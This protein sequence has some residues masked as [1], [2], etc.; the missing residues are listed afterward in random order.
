MSWIYL[1]LAGLLE[2]CWALAMKAS[3]G[4]S[5]PVPTLLMAA[6][7]AASFWLLAL[8]MRTL[9]LSTAYAVWTG[10]GAVGSFLVGIII[11]G[12]PAGALKM[13]AAALIAGGIVLMKV[14]G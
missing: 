8:A 9:P 10:I 11:L 13:T 3:D 5:R 4:F 2:V 7:M 14:A 1:C 12:E 6:T